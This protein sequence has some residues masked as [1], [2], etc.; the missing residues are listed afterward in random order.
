VLLDEVELLESEI[1]FK[2][3]PKYPREQ[4]AL[5]GKIAGGL[6]S[7]ESSLEVCVAKEASAGGGCLRVGADAR[8][9]RCDGGSVVVIVIVSII[10]IVRIII[11]N[12]GWQ[13]RQDVDS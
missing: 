12:G 13:K 9:Y 6:R 11:T 2:S 4:V 10:I 1:F 3:F 7:W 8:W 5:S